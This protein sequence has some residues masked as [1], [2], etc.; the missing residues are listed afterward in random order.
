MDISGPS[1]ELENEEI[2]LNPQ[3]TEDFSDV[4]IAISI[5]E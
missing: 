5:C 1:D 2:Y 3:A 4:P